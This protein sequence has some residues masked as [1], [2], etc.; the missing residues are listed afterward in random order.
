MTVAYQVEI[1]RK[2]RIKNSSKSHKMLYGQ[3]LTPRIIASFMSNLA[4]KYAGD[5]P[6]V[7]ILDPGAGQGIL[8]SSLAES[9]KEKHPDNFIHIDAYEIDKS[10]TIEL[11]NHLTQLKEEK[12]IEYNLINQ[13]FIESVTYDIGWGQNK[14]YSHIIMNPPY[15]KLNVNSPHYRHLKKRI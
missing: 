7:S 8:C 3:Y 5:A 12:N 6:S 11:E 13:D 10:I 1:N 14:K 2:K 4:I 15:K 9:I